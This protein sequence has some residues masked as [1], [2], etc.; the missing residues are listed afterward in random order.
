MP[1]FQ[2]TGTGRV[3]IVDDIAN[4][5]APTI[6]ELGDVSNVDL[7][8]FMRQDGL[9]RSQEAALVDTATALDLFDTT[10]IGTRSGKFEM[11]LYRDFANGGIAADDAAWEAL[12]IGTRTHIV[13]APGGFTG[14]GG[15]AAAGDK[16]EVWTLAV[17]ARSNNAIAKDTAQTFTVTFAVTAVPSDDAVVA[18]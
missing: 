4:V 10:D 8:R 16:V 7:T 2:F 15:I 12:P 9:D 11:T 17:S 1:R 14:V 6:A 13:V 3:R 18:A 5:D